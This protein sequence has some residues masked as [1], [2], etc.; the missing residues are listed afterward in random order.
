MTGLLGL[1]ALALLPQLALAAPNVVVSI[2]PIHSL[3]AGVMQGVGVPALIVEGAASAHTYN[4]KPSN[5]RNLEQADLVVWVGHGMEAFLE[6][7]LETLGGGATILTLEDAP[8]LTHLAFRDGGSFEPEAEDAHDH[9]TEAGGAAHDDHDADPHG[10]DTHLWLDPMNAKA[11]TAD[12]A[13]TLVRLDP[14][15]AATYEK[16]AAAMEASLDTLNAQIARAVAP[17]K[18]K[19]FIVFHDAYHYFEHRYGLYVAGSVTV[20]PEVMPGAERVRE[21]QDKI[22]RHGAACV[23]AEPQF[24]SKLIDV[25]A[26]GTDA[27]GG[28]LDPLGADLNPGPA[29]YPQL[30]RNLAKSLVACLGS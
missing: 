12:I 4:L 20:S 3:V 8:G 18:D 9:E 13:R 24:N 22:A 2:K 26:E 27:R 19:P 16:N 25:V 6:K 14:D 21:I 5:A 29:L 28:V 11:M 7:P 17:I 23:F 1:P 10:Y 30:M 15:N